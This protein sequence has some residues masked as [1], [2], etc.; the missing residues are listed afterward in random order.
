MR[1]SCS[2]CG[3]SVFGL[4]DGTPPALGANQPRK[5]VL[6]PVLATS[7]IRS[8]KCVTDDALRPFSAPSLQQAERKKSCFLCCFLPCFLSRISEVASTGHLQSSCRGRDATSIQ[9]VGSTTRFLRQGDY[10]R[11]LPVIR[12]R[13]RALRQIMYVLRTSILARSRSGA[14][15][16][17]AIHRNQWDRT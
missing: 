4:V 11:E 12:H 1:R 8:K 9:H 17:C 7:D 10:R 2:A 15:N 16:A 14:G 6:L 13:L 3:G 5:N